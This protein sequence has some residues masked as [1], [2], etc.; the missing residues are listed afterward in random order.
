MP[1]YVDVLNVIE[2]G[3]VLKNLILWIYQGWISTLVWTSVTEFA[4]SVFNAT[5]IRFTDT[6]KVTDTL[7]VM[8]EMIIA[9]IITACSNQHVV[10]PPSIVGGLVLSY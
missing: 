7:N 2:F 10:I 6:R 9:I 4:Q 1:C 8:I 5:R 3:A